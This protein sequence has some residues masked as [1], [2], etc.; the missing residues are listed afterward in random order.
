LGDTELARKTLLVREQ[1]IAGEDL[2]KKL[3]DIVKNR[4]EALAM[5]R[6]TPLH[7]DASGSVKL[8]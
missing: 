5:L 7:P 8:A 4:C 1:K 6:G 3:C 2:R